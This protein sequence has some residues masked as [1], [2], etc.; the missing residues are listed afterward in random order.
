M[1]RP[2]L[3]LDVDGV[4]NAHSNTDRECKGIDPTMLH[5]LSTITIATNCVIVVSS[6]WRFIPRRM[7]RLLSSLFTIGSG[8][9]GT[10]PVLSKKSPGGIYLGMSRGDEIQAW[11][12]E[13]KNTTEY[14]TDNIVIL[15]DDNDMKHLKH[16]LIL[17]ESMTGLTAELAQEAIDMIRP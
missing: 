12:D 8:V 11:I 7:Q 15:D 4:L 14:D 1:K 6:T 2:I 9:I 17:A 3:F 16:R 10:T 5:H 13:Y